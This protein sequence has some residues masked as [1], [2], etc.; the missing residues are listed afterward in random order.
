MRN[1]MTTPHHLTRAGI[2]ALLLAWM[3]LATPALAADQAGT[4]DRISGIVHVERQGTRALLRQ[5]EPV[6][7]GDRIRTG[8][9]ATA[10]IL[11]VDDSTLSLSRNSDLEITEYLFDAEQER[12]S[13][14]NLWMGRARA[15]VSR[16]VGDSGCTV[17]TPT[18]VA[19]VR[20]TEF[21]LE[22]APAGE[23]Y[24]DT[25]PRES[26]ELYSTEIVV[27]SG[28][29]AV[30]SLL[31]DLGEVLLGPGTGTSVGSGAPP[32]PPRQLT[33]GEIQ[34]WQ[35]SASTR[36][37]PGS[38]RGHYAPT[39]YDP[40]HERQQYEPS[41]GQDGPGGLPQGDPAGGDSSDASSGGATPPI[42]QEPVDRIGTTPVIIE[43]HRP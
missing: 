10:R 38:E 21:V 25:D 6:H 8:A 36:S 43:I 13:A 28:S 40:M 32:T 9:N 15:T 37:E 27:V 14:L 1:G 16:F 18:A 35:Q 2:C 42:Q 23:E 20:G 5:G 11:F 4:A 7:V 41:P 31:A 17:N 30:S 19:G 34:Q 29:V 26:P 39:A 3:G 12:R 24:P 22:V 33:P